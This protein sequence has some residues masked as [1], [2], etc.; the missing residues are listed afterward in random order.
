MERPPVH[1]LHE[2]DWLE[3][4]IV[5]LLG[6]GFRSTAAGEN[7]DRDGRDEERTQNAANL[8]SATVEFVMT[9]TLRVDAHHAANDL[10]SAVVLPAS[11][12]GTGVLPARVH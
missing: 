7:E 11:R 9:A 12:T 3:A 8:S 10:P 6:R 2:G 4:S 1:L 5:L